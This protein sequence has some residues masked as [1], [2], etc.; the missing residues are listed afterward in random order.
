MKITKH[1]LQVGWGQLKKQA[2]A[3]VGQWPVHHIAG[4]NLQSKHRDRCLAN[5]NIAIVFA[6]SVTELSES[7]LPV[8]S[9]PI[10]VS[11]TTKH[12]PRLEVKDVSAKEQD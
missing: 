3:S 7:L 2:G 11:N 5:S 4:R 1:R 9:D 12:V 10:N 8:P 6:A